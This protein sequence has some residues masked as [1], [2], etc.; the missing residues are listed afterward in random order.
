MPYSLHWT[1][2]GVWVRHRGEVRHAEV[3]A[4][5]NEVIADARSTD[6]RFYVSDFTAITAL[7]ATPDDSREL[8]YLDRVKLTYLRIRHLF[9]AGNHPQL[10]ALGPIY[11]EHLGPT[12]VEIVFCSSA[13]ELATAVRARYGEDLPEASA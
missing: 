3:V 10:L 8:A 1:E 4:A 2:Q 11:R 12:D 9:V 6:C 5:G 7:H 13:S